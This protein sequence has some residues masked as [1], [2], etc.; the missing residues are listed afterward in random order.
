MRVFRI[1]ILAHLIIFISIGCNKR[2]TNQLSIK[3]SAVDAEIHGDILKGPSALNDPDRFVWGSSVLKGTDGKYHMVYNTWKCGDS[4]PPFSDSWVLHSEL[5]YAVSD[6]P[7]K[8]FRFVKIVLKA[9]RFDGLPNNWDAQM[10]T[11]PHLKEFNG[12]YYLY[13]VGGSDPG[14]QQKGSKGE[15][16]NKRNRVQQSLKIGVI[17]FNNFDALVTG[18][19]T[20]P[21]NPLLSPRTRVKPDN[22]TNPSPEGTRPKPDNI[23]VVNPSVVQ[24]PSDGKYLLFF[25]GNVY[26]PHWRGVHGVAISDSPIGPFIPNEDYVFDIKLANGK[27]ASAEDPFVWYHKTDHKFYAIIKDFSGKITDTEPGL[28]MLESKDGI[29][30]IQQEKP[31]ILKKEVTL[32]NGEIVKVKRLERPQLLISENGNPLVLYC[33]CSIVDVNSRKDGSS[34]N[35]QIPLITE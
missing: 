31:F 1:S 27:I 25:K 29:K 8:N 5:A 3:T 35:I 15:H 28:A 4:L 32:K 26:N 19:F 9:A 33:A 24:R 13:Y 30:W 23:I 21:K 2:K 10:V 14:V 7:D 16:L 11:N 22:I 18:N 20:R 17:A 34:F 12:K 6:F